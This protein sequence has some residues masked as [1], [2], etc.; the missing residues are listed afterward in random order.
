MKAQI[1]GAKQALAANPKDR[2][3]LFGQYSGEY[4]YSK[5]VRGDNTPEY[6]KYL[7]YLDA[8]EL[9]PDFQ[10]ITWREFLVDLL[11]GKTEKPYVDGIHDADHDN[12]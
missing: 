8:G 11:A 12:E 7:G 5:Y 6:A 4:N 1:A 10:P 3:A 2:M 9:Y